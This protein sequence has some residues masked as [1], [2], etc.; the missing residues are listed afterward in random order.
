MK[1]LPRRVRKRLLTTLLAVAAALCAATAA[2]AAYPPQIAPPSQ[3]RP[4]IVRNQNL[5]RT[6]LIFSNTHNYGVIKIK[7]DV[8][9]NYL[10]DFTKYQWVYTV[11]NFTFN[12]NPPVSNGFSGFE[13]ALPGVVPDLANVTAPDGIPPWLVNCCSGLPVEWDLSNAVDVVGGGTMPGQTEVYSFTTLPRLVTLST[14]WFHTWQQ[15]VQTDIT[16]YPAGDGPEAPDLLSEP[17]QEL[18]C[19]HDALGNYTCQVLPAGQCAAIGGVIVASCNN[20]PPITPTQRKTWGS[21]KQ[22]YR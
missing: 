18:C 11:T 21:V 8:L 3:D 7:V 16:N 17:N 5:S 2:L 6:G 22:R 19:T 9:D 15:N 4:H 14:G 12:P 13:L 10:G 20:C 1:S